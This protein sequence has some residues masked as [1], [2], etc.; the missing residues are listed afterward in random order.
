MQSS[1]QTEFIQIN[2][3]DALGLMYAPEGA[4]WLASRPNYIDESRHYGYGN[5]V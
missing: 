5:G 4:I 2:W 3:L 1:V